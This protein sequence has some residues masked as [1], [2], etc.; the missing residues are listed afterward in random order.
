MEGAERVEELG[1]R[2]DKGELGERA[3]ETWRVGKLGSTTRLEK[4]RRQMEPPY[5]VGRMSVDRY[6]GSNGEARHFIS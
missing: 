6:L 4:Q 2:D 3:Y 1:L 5:W